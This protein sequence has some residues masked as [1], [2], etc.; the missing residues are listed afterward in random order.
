MRQKASRRRKW[1]V[2]ASGSP[3]DAS[4]IFPSPNL[5]CF[6]PPGN[7]AMYACA[8]GV[9]FPLVQSLPPQTSVL[10]L[11]LSK[12]LNIQSDSVKQRGLGRCTPLC[13]SVA[14]GVRIAQ[15]AGSCSLET[16]GAWQAGG[17]LGVSALIPR[18]GPRG[19][20]LRI[21]GAARFTGRDAARGARVAAVLSGLWS[22]G[23]GN[24]VDSERG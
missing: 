11:G 18:E 15:P 7:L 16:G 4:A 8:L 13:D 24:R 19:L 6:F 21:A 9:A 2:S 17:G 12:C 5:T 1:R 20:T 3:S 10:F 22:A 14:S 23:G